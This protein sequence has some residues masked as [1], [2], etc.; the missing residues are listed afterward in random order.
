ME[1][2]KLLVYIV[3]DNTNENSEETLKRLYQGATTLFLT[4]ERE[5]YLEP[6]R[7]ST[8]EPFCKSS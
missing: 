7:T 6:N 2:H 4:V 1:S 8:M 3:A 5:A